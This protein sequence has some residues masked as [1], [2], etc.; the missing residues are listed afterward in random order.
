MNYLINISK[1]ELQKPYTLNACFNRRRAYRMK[2]KGISSIGR[3]TVLH[4][5]GQVFEP[6][7]P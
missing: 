6:P 7:I 5:V 2:K 4:T 3:A 1:N